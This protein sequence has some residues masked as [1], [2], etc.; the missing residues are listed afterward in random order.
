M[1]HKDLVDSDERLTCRGCGRWTL[2]RVAGT[3]H[4]P[5]QWACENLHCPKNQRAGRRVGPVEVV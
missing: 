2:K 5:R 3:Y 4:R 1:S